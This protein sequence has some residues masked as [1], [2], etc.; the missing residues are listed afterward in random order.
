M[1]ATD[2][3]LMDAHIGGDKEAF[4]ILLRRYG[5]AVLG[6]LMKMTHNTHHAEDL[7][8][9]TFRRAYEH[10]GQF[11][12]QCFKPWLFKI[13]THAAISRYRK[14]KNTPTVSLSRPL[15]P[16]GVHCQTL[17]NTLPA[18][19]AEPVRQLERAEQCR[20]VQ[21]ALLKL[22]EKQRAALIMS[23]YHKLTCSQIAEA[24]DC[25]VGSVKTHLFRAL[26]RLRTL[27]PEPAG[28]IQ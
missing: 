22:P 11:R 26:K 20:Q 28:G 19:T 23:Y 7:F 8:Q 5:P 13:A 18:D 10:A 27:L 9:E 16:D 15:C 4:E 17:E 6:Y 2:R 3:N 24:M 14:E 25:S 1:T 12:G 21:S